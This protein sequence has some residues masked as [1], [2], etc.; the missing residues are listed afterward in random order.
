MD[1]VTGLRYAPQYKL[2]GQATARSWI[3]ILLWKV[4]GE[5]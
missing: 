3:N 2:S 1:F 4:R 5:N